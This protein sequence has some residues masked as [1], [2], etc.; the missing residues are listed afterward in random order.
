MCVVHLENVRIIL[1]MCL[2]H[3]ENVR[4]I[5]KVS[6][7]SKKCPDN[8]QNVLNYHYKCT[9]WSTF[10]PF[11][12]LRSCKHTFYRHLS[13]I[14]KLTRFTRFIWKVFATKS[15]CPES[16]HFFWLCPVCPSYLVRFLGTPALSLVPP[17]E[18]GGWVSLE[19]GHIMDGLRL[20]VGVPLL[21]L[22]VIFISL[23]RRYLCSR[24]RWG[25]LI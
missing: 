3:L 1:K 2:V 14:R 15:C 17:L 12:C 6:W 5:W 20:L 4:M 23:W 24:W 8:L 11:L 13:R 25:W 22:E 10:G 9:P 18:L 19:V 16:F 7:Q 21:T